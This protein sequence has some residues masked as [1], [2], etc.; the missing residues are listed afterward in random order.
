MGKQVQGKRFG[1]ASVAVVCTQRTRRTVKAGNQWKCKN[2]EAPIYIYRGLE[3]ELQ[4]G[5]IISNLC[6]KWTRR[7]RRIGKN[8]KNLEETE[9]HPQIVNAGKWMLTG[10]GDRG[11]GGGAAA[12]HEGRLPAAWCSSVGQRVSKAS[13]EARGRSARCGR[14]K[15]V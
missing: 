12:E 15:K 2:L 11:G 4:V 8:T 13:E 1:T 5:R 6:P 9:A 10:V 14:K 7:M 3:Q